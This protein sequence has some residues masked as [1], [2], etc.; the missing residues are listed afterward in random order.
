MQTILPIQATEIKS[1][2]TSLRSQAS[3]EC[4]FSP[5]LVLIQICQLWLSYY[6]EG[7]G[8]P[9]LRGYRYLLIR[10][11]EYSFLWQG[12]SLGHTV[13]ASFL[14]RQRTVQCNAAGCPLKT[15]PLL[16]STKYTKGLQVMLLISIVPHLQ[17]NLQLCLLKCKSQCFQ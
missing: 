14:D 7:S 8:L 11:A 13:L 16:P 5:G 3:K 9:V 10:P 17:C 6:G 4:N 12:M 1:Q 15:Q 2:K